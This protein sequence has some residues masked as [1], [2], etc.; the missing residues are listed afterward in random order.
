ML[1]YFPQDTTIEMGPTAVIPGSH[2]WGRDFVRGITTNGPGEDSPIDHWDM[3]GPTD[4]LR[5]KRA[6]PLRTIT[7]TWLPM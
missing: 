7:P 3:T 2:F 1:E 5:S 4:T 6:S